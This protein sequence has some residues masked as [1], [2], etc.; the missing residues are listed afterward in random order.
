MT[1]KSRALSRSIND[2]NTINKNYVTADLTEMIVVSSTDDL[3]VSG[4][5]QGDQGYVTATNR[6]YLWSGSGWYNIALIN[7]SPYYTT[8]PAGSYELNNDG[9]ATTITINAVDSEGLPITFTAITDSDFDTFATITKDSDNGRIFTVTPD[10]ENGVPSASNTGSVTFRASD[11]VNQTDAVSSF[12]LSFSNI[13]DNS[14]YTTMLMRATGNNIANG[15]LVYLDSENSDG[16]LFTRAGST[17]SSSLSPYRSGGYS[18]WFDGTDDRLETDNNANLKFGS[19]DW[20]VECWVYST[21]WYNTSTVLEL[22]P[23]DV[24]RGPLLI[25]V[26]SGNLTFYSSSDNSTWNLESA[27]TL[28]SSVSNRTWY[29]IAIVRNGGTLKSYVDGVEQSSLAISGGYTDANPRLRIGYGFRNG[30]GNGAYYTGYIRDLRVVIG[31]AV[32]TGAFTPPTEPLTAITNTQFLGCGAPCHIDKSTNRIALANNSFPNTYPFGPYNYEPWI[33]GT[34]G[35]SLYMD[36]DG[37]YVKT[38]AGTGIGNFGTGDF[39]VELW[40][41]PETNPSAAN[42]PFI[43]STDAGSSGNTWQIY[44]SSDKFRYARGTGNQD[45]T[46]GLGVRDAWHH[47]VVQRKSSV[48]QMWVNGIRAV[49]DIADTVNYSTDDNI[50]IGVNR[51]VNNYVDGYIADVKI[52]KGT[53]LYTVGDYIDVPTEPVTFDTNT[54]FIMNNKSDTNIYDATG[55]ITFRTVGNVIAS[56]TERKFTTSSAIYF[57][58]N[59]DYII[60]ENETNTNNN[61]GIVG[62]GG[63]DDFTIEFWMRLNAVDHSMTIF[64]TRPRNTNGAYITITHDSSAGIKL[65]AQQANRI[66]GSVLSVDTWYHIALVRN[67]GTTTLYTDGVSDGTYSDTNGYNHGVAAPVIGANGYNLSNNQFH[68]Y[69]QDLRFT[70][71]LARYTA[72]FTPPTAEYEL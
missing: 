32:Y 25:Y 19:D 51:G 11:G 29:H 14:A 7:T 52:T 53:A 47:V 8:S 13:I 20:T 48:S 42:D 72:N 59:G 12:T 1:S 15:D 31:S 16:I 38:A 57:D 27:E 65:Y 10:S 41:R 69:I 54:V 24:L 56:T 63:I 5:T 6:L 70:R 45:S 49:S 36:G 28:V 30:G 33:P 60:G 71:G 4:N 55:S 44:Y 23:S 39:T 17:Q 26:A 34:N 61:K 9:T 62:V 3:P 68:G 21:N 67:N 37:D 50:Q 66:T 43:S 58:G 40:W 22:A 35:G 46:T 18:T 64:D 2:N